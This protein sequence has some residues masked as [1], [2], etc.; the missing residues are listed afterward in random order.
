MMLMREE[1]LSMSIPAVCPTCQSSVKLVDHLA[2]KKVR[3]KKC[4]EVFLV[5]Q[6]T[7]DRER[8]DDERR[9]R[10]HRDEGDDDEDRPGARRRTG[11]TKERSSKTLLILGGSVG[12]IVVLGRI[13]LLIWKLAA[14]ENG[15]NAA[16]PNQPAGPIVKGPVVK[17]P[18]VKA[19]AIKV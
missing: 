6:A 16:N 4:Q 14:G 8:E 13:G 10:R 5:P 17:G 2:G 11:K 3:C 15:E 12:A 18:V 1:D 7:S 9:P 19:P